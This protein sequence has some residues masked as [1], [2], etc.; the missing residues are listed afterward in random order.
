MKSRAKPD[1]KTHTKQR[2]QS[3]SE[4]ETSKKKVTL[5]PFISD[6][7]SRL[8]IFFRFR[9]ARLLSSLPGASLDY[10]LDLER[11]IYKQA[12]LDPSYY[13]SSVKRLYYSLFH[14]GKSLS[15]FS[16]EELAGM[17]LDALCVGTDVEK[18]TSSFHERKERQD[19]LMQESASEDVSSSSVKCGRCKSPRILIE[20]RQTRSADEG[21][22][23]FATCQACGLRWKM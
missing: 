12:A 19:V 16:P 17:S 3:V 8:H 18:W 11:V 4:K 13:D 2:C 22:T 20:Q 5:A 21:M 15:S 23:V 6:K 1:S 7:T 9:A 14:N 10:A